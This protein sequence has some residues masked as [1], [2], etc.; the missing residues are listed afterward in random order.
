MISTYS[1][2]FSHSHKENIK[3]RKNPSLSSFVSFWWN[4]FGWR[5]ILL[6]EVSSP[7]DCYRW[8]QWDPP[9]QG[10]Q[11]PHS[12]RALPGTRA[13]QLR[14]RLSPGLCHLQVK[15]SQ[16]LGKVKTIVSWSTASLLFCNAEGRDQL[17]PADSD[18]CV[19]HGMS[20]IIAG[21]SYYRTTGLPRYL[22]V[23]PSHKALCK[24][25]WSKAEKPLS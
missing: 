6:T 9:V 24:P 3:L 16:L 17:A 8:R 25:K 1:I 11:G 12:C 5:P 20:W 21:K 15:I 14:H 22:R 10:G 2:V 13:R 23:R 7:L 4:V 19:T 18:E